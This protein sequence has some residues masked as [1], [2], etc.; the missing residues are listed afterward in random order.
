MLLVNISFGFVGLGSAT[1][2]RDTSNDRRS[3]A[4]G[5]CFR[6]ILGLFLSSNLADLIQVTLEHRGIRDVFGRLGQL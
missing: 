5:V 2:G 3:A 1:G 4:D 6:L